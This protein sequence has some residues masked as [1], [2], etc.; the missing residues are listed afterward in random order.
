MEKQTDAQQIY[1]SYDTSGWV[2][3]TSSEINMKI[4]AWSWDIS[5][6]DLN[7][8]RVM[9]LLLIFLS[10]AEHGDTGVSWDNIVKSFYRFVTWVCN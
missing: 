4:V 1:F 7:Q 3:E 9:I 8:E 2:L 6:H 5:F 10:S